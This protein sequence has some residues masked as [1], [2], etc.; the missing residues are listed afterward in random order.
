MKYRMSI[1]CVAALVFVSAFPPVQAQ[2]ANFNV[3]HYFSG[4]EGAFPYA[5]PILSGN[6]LYG[7][8]VTDGGGDDGTVFSLNIATT[9]LLDLHDFSDAYAPAYDNNDGANPEARLIL[10]GN[11]L[12]GTAYYGGSNGFGSMFSLN[13][14]T[15][16]F[17][18]LHSFSAATYDSQSGLYYNS[19]G[20]YPE[21]GLVLAGNTLYGTALYGGS[22]GFGTV[23]SFNTSTS[24]FTNIYTFTG[25]NDGAFPLGDLIVSGDTLYGTANAGGSNSF[26]S[27]F[28]VN[29]NGSNF[30]GLY[31][32]T[33]G[34]DGAYPLQGSLLLWSNTLYGT[35]LQS[36]TNG[37]GT[38]FSLSAS[39]SDFT[40]L[41]IFSETNAA[42]A[43]SDGASPAADLI[44]SNNTLY[45]VAYSGGSNGNGTIF[46]LSL[47]SGGSGFTTLYS[48]TDTNNADGT[49]SDGAL[50]QAG[51]VLL[52]NTLYG[53]ASGGGIDG[54]GAV[55]ALVLGVA[56]S[57]AIARAGRQVV[58][59]WPA[60]ATNYALQ[61][62]TNLTSRSWSD[63]TNGI[64]TA[65]ANF[66][67]TNAVAG[68]AAY[69]RLQQQ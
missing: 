1:L 61:T 51:L 27:V 14:A 66:V 40:T 26:G 29:T 6:T 49:N 31:S 38:I 43:N 20:I 48:F 62:T 64:T 3:L 10:S 18:D 44:I 39:G 7:T 15:S 63:I 30:I 36:G 41:Y 13:D 59:S 69:F 57:L 25:G 60:S 56:P 65:G 33:N 2:S 12:Y 53:A 32:F 11:T 68:S 35:T 19:D 16:N 17:M 9:N 46:S 5:G 23:F 54:D 24:Y 4:Y 22:N 37:N 47:S 67:L 34:S 8:T 42:G 45:G 28:S 52:G 55:F 50:P 58:L 21:A